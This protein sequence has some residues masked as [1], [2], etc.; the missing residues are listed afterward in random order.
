[1]TQVQVASAAP[2]TGG[3]SGFFGNLFG[4]KRESQNGDARATVAS[5]TP[6]TKPQPG[7][8]APSK[9]A[10]TAAL[11]GG[12]S[13]PDPQRTDDKSAKVATAKPKPL[14]ARPEAGA[15][16]EATPSSTP[17]LLNG[18]APTVP[19]GGFENRFGA[20]H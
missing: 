6:Q 4:S 19:T 13:K 18:A 8:P 5:P 20:W 3:I 16:R 1:S 15:E 17:N 9:P 2:S 14:P 12:R 11:G 7:G 10:Q